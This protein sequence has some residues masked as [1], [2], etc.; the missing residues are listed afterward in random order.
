MPKTMICVRNDYNP[1]NA[2]QEASYKKNDSITE[3]Q[4]HKPNDMKHE[5]TSEQLDSIVED[6]AQQPDGNKIDIGSQLAP[7]IEAKFVIVGDS[8]GKTNLIRVFC[9][10][11][12]VEGM[13]VTVFDEGT[14]NIT[15]DGQRVQ[16]GWWD[17]AG[18]EDYDKL[19]PLSYPNTDVYIVCF[20]I[21]YPDSF[22][23]AQE[24]WVPEIKKH[25]HPKIPIILVGTKKDER[26]DPNILAELA[27]FR[28]QPI[29]Y[30]EGQAMAKCVGAITYLECSAK[31][32][33]GVTEVFEAATRAMLSARNRTKAPKKK[34]GKT[35]DACK[36][37]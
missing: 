14:M 30:E 37:M 11:E 29:K 10:R 17:T 20:S 22:E 13:P 21:V 32:N 34:K 5:V 35:P 28:Q 27:R 8:V 12:F 2:D 4:A 1:I 9:Q 33:D 6:Q 18:Q 31:N 3:N 19:R 36:P 26:N 25:C 7:P 16:V 15:V 24:K 23:N